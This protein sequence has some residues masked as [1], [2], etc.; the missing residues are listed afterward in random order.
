MK[1]LVLE[2]EDVKFEQVRAHVVEVIPEA[3]IQREKNW[4]HYS[5]AVENAKFDLILLD[6]L[7]PRSAKDGT[8]EDHHASLVETTRDYHRSPSARPPLY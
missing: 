4:L 1:I 7:V 8:V 3:I 6:L 5:R 2:D